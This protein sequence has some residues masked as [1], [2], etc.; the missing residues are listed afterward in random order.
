VVKLAVFPGSMG[1][2]ANRS[3]VGLAGTGSNTTIDSQ[4]RFGGSEKYSTTRF[5]SSAG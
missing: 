4:N 2:P 3:A 1:R 5:G